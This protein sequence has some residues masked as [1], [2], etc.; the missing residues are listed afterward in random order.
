MCRY[1]E[2][3]DIIRL[4]KNSQKIRDVA[5]VQTGGCGSGVKPGPSKYCHLQIVCYQTMSKCYCDLQKEVSYCM[6]S[7]N[8]PSLIN[9]KNKP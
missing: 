6:D 4:L 8:L 3:K 5:K 9:K 1:D 7:K 2:L